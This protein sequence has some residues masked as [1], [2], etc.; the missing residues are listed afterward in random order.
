MMKFT[1]LKQNQIKKEINRIH[2]EMESM[3]INSEEYKNA[4]G[5]LK[6]LHEIESRDLFGISSDTM[7]VVAG[8]ILGLILV[9]KHEELNVITSKALGFVIKGRV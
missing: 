2:S 9:L 1:K 7:A 3:D 4:I 5:H 6:S 8:N